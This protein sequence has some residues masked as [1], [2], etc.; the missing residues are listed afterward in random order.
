MIF[1]APHQANWNLPAMA[2]RLGKLSLSVL[3][4]AQRNPE[5]RGADQALAQHHTGGLHRRG[6]RPAADPPGARR[7]PQRRPADGPSLQGRRAGAVFRHRGAD[8]DDPGA[9]RDQARHRP[10]ADP[11]RAARGRPLSDHAARADPCRS[12]D[13]RPAA[14]RPAHDRA[15]QRA[16]RAL[17]PRA[18]RAVDLRQAALAEGR[19]PPGPRPRRARLRTVNAAPA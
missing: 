19:D 10:G 4:R 16:F 7:R 6:R 8:R 15:G 12:C 14:R 2:G 17:D 9:A 1:V 3:F 11:D 5:A 18:A 13:R